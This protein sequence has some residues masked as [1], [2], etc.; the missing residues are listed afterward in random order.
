M[1]EK[2][3]TK[4]I[5][6]PLLP[7][8]GIVV[9]PNMII[10]FD[11]GRKKSIQAVEKSMIDDQLI[12]L[13]AQKEMDIDDPAPEDLFKVGTVAKIKQILKLPGNV[14]RILVEG[15]NRAIIKN[16]EETEEFFQVQ[17]KEEEEA[18]TSETEKQAMVRIAENVIEEYG[19]VNQRIDLGNIKNMLELGDLGT[20]GDQIASNV[21]LPYE[22]KQK[23]LDEF[24]PLERLQT[25]VAI[26]EKEIQIIHLQKNIQSQVKQKID[27]NQKEYYLR[28]QLK[29]IQDALGD[30][31][32]VQG[33]VEAYRE[34]LGKIDAPDE[35]VEKIERE[36]QRMIKIPNGSSEG[37][38]VRNYIEWMLDLPWNIHTEESKDIDD[39]E[40]I[41]NEDHY[42]L[43][44]VK[45][46]ILEYLAVRQMAPKGNSPIL[47][48]VGPPGVG[49]T[50]VARSIAQALNRKYERI[51]L[52]GMR[53]EAD[54]RGHRRTYVGAIP[55]R[56][57][58]GLKQ[59]GSNNPLLLLD[60]LDK[61]SK[62]FRGDPGAALLEVLDSEQNKSFRDH[63]IEVPLDLSNVLFI[64]TANTL[65][66][67]PRPLIDRLEI[68][69]L[70]S[71]T[72]VEKI[73]IATDYLLPK[74]LEKHGLKKGQVRMD[75]DIIN[76]I[77]LHYTKE[78]GVRNLER[79]MADICRKAVK[80][81]L[82]K[83]KKYVKITDK[84][85][86]E[87]LGI[88]KFRYE[89]IAEKSYVG[90]AK[91]LAWT[92]V[93]GDTL[94]IEVNAMKG[95]G[96]FELTGQLGDVMKESAKAGI[97]YIRAN[98]GRFEIPATF[99]EDMDLHIHIPEGAVPKD[100]PSAGITM[101]TAML[102]ALT[103][104]PIKN[105]V[106]MTGEITLRGRVLP[107]GGLEEKILAAVRAGVKKV[108]IPYDNKKD[109]EDITKEI[110]KHIEVVFVK[111]MEQVLEHALE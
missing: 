25:A 47:C 51:S 64:A 9:F 28:E 53:D 65:E 58:F 21:Q 26:L 27:K 75:E 67:I 61:M 78:T 59:A 95:K 15:K 37:V 57:V 31:E 74:Q 69:Q 66:T 94:S 36:L 12:F 86:E 19:K 106:A 39:A 73:H 50:S 30:S 88:P 48:L 6:M 111:N 77:I 103:N 32:G 54:I 80:Q 93:G 3:S 10:N 62:D 7:L 107:V 71:Y 22:E 45:E 89:K 96:K 87:Y 56:L 34:Q 83:G 4:T 81:I 8:R 52:G 99:Y 35:V 110:T 2:V 76:Q 104:R 18:E 82:S 79:K 68:I 55:G 23:I 16:Y 11:V 72:A 14:I 60:E 29:V 100:G 102:S 43:K 42:G 105:D 85:L 108:L 13:V 92:P 46:R 33:E 91:G 41:L 40:R 5:P 38:V 49:K 44:K 98:G 109:V 101:A 63:Y 84:N 20:I 70:S 1:E 97:S 90:I 17:L 24:D